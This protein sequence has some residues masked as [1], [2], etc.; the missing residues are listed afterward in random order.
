MK[1]RS[2]LEVNGSAYFNIPSHIREEMGI[3]KGDNLCIELV[4]KNIVATL[5]P[6]PASMKTNVAKNIPKP[7]KV[8]DVNE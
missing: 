3:K 7:I 5:V 6:K 8:G 1:I 2:V 4:E